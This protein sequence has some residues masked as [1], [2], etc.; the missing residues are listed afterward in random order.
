MWRPN[1]C[2]HEKWFMN[3]FLNLKVK[4]KVF[5]CNFFLSLPNIEKCSVVFLEW[6]KNKMLRIFVDSVT[7]VSQFEIL[8]KFIKCVLLNVYISRP[9]YCL[10]PFIMV[11]ISCHYSI[12]WIT[13]EKKEQICVLSFATILYNTTWWALEDPCQTRWDNHTPS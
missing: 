13:R 3:R 11:D 1:I 9:N 5:F 2:W 10:K 6:N 4:W 7:F 8:N 12:V